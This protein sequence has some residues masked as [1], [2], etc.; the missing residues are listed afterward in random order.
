MACAYVP[1]CRQ[2]GRWSSCSTARRIQDETDW[3]PSAARR[4]I[5]AGISG[6]IPTGIGAVNPTVRRRG[7]PCLS[8]PASY[9]SSSIMRLSRH[10]PVR[11]ACTLCTI[12]RR[13]RR[14][15][16][17]TADE[18]AS[19]KAGR[20]TDFAGQNLTGSRFEDVYLTCADERASR[21][22]V[23]SGRGAEHPTLARVLD[24]TRASPSLLHL[25][26]E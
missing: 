19:W 21:P 16:R 1:T 13:C 22:R 25:E 12:A 20:V 8:G 2:V 5:S 11:P 4:R 9:S 6:G 26:D 3:S 24:L 17:T 15:P 7:G 18:C 23:Q 14:G 10:G